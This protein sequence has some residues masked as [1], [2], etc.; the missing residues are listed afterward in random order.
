MS[1]FILAHPLRHPLIIRGFC[2]GKVSVIQKS[3]ILIGQEA[4]G[5]Q[6]WLTESLI[7]LS[8]QALLDKSGV[9]VDRPKGPANVVACR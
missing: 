8:E 6:R 5:L 9:L 2:I 7:S 4:A 1:S 3:K